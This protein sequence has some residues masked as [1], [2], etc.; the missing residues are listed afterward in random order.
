MKN[1]YTYFLLILLTVFLSSCFWWESVDETGLAQVETES[2][3]IKL[4]NTWDAIAANELPLPKSGDIVLAYASPE[5]RQW[6][7]NNI[8][9][10]ADE[11]HQNESSVWLMNNSANF[12]KWGLKGFTLIEQ[13]NINFHDEEIWTVLSFRGR[14][15]PNTPELTY[16]QTARSCWDMSYFLTV[17]L[18]EQLETYDKYEYLLQSFRCK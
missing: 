9:V 5:E 15:N 12:L 7:I 8:V 16:I 1:C 18:A 4:P 10:L 13:K 6:Y 2:F 3:S 11:N 17:S 14:Y